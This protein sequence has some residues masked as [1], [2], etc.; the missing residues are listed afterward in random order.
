MNEH[1]RLTRR[2]AAMLSE[3]QD[4]VPPATDVMTAFRRR[5]AQARRRRVR[6]LAVA[7][8]VMVV[9]AT[10]LI[11]ATWAPGSRRPADLAGPVRG[12]GQIQVWTL[13][14]QSRVSALRACAADFSRSADIEVDIASYP[15]QRYQQ[16]LR[17]ALTS[18]DPPDIFF[19][20][21]GGGMKEMVRAKQVLDLTE[22]LRAR[23]QVAN[24][25][26]PEVLTAGRVDGRQYGL[27][28]SGVEPIMLFYNRR[29]FAQA[30]LRPPETYADLLALVDAFKARGTDP[31]A[32]AGA[33]GW[34]ELMYLMYLVDRI[35]G[36]RPFA[37][38]AA[39]RP[40]AWSHPAVL[41]AARMARELVERGAFGRDFTTLRYDDGGSS[42]RLASGQAA[43]QLMG[44]WEYALQ[45]TLDPDFVRD[46]DLGWVPF[47]A[48][49]GGAGDPTNVVGAPGSY[50]SVSSASLDAEQA[51]DV[52]F[53]LLTCN[54]YVDALLHAGEVPA[55]T[56]VAARAAGTPHAEFIRSTH[57]LVAVAPSSTLAWDQALSPTAGA[58]LNANLRRLFALEFTAEQFAAAMS[59]V[60]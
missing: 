21:G 32:L 60:R 27:P 15:N 48:V 50:F 7:C 43:M 25:F 52:L 19:H 49:P 9:A 30:D 6:T 17:E 20:W 54:R 24:A 47:P 39:G 37:D 3:A 16:Q 55:V 10:V 42:G 36:P 40:G 12:D 28:A 45:L 29:V 5:Y 26:A 58:A 18:T 14:S 13:R 46:G 41:Q 31:L 53:S 4:A 2:L 22:A 51:V 38:I 59:E 44:S 23:P 34:S 1:D 33:D 57:R 35:G 11:G 56:D 8:A